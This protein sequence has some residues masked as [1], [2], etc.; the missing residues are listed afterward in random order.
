MDIDD[1][2]T[3]ARVLRALVGGDKDQPYDEV[4]DWIDDAEAL[5]AAGWPDAAAAVEF[6]RRRD[7]L[8]WVWLSRRRRLVVLR[9]D[10]ELQPLAN[11]PWGLRCESLDRVFDL[12]DQLPEPAHGRQ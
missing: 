1:L 6:D 4:R 3:R 7:T 8:L 2:R 10:G 9:E 5:L 11:A 12:L